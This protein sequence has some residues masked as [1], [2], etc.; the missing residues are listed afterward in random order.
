MCQTSTPSCWEDKEA[1]HITNEPSFEVEDLFHWWKKQDQYVP[2]VHNPTRER[3]PYLLIS[4]HMVHM[5]MELMIDQ[6]I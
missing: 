1:Y 5:R 4:T 6:I 3:R 2:E